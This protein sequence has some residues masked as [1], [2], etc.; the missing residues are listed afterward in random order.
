MHVCRVPVACD[1]DPIG[2]RGDLLEVCRGELDIGGG[3]V[4]CRRWSLVVPGMGTIVGCCARIQANA[5]CAGV[6]LLRAAIAATKRFGVG[7]GSVRRAATPLRFGWCAPSADP[8]SP[9]APLTGH[10]TA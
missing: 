5:T 9:Q 7:L 8:T 10:R 3:G 1:V 2:G 6:A 4:S